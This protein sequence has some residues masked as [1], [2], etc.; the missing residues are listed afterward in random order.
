M[1]TSVI[2]LI[3]GILILAFLGIAIYFIVV[4]GKTP[5]NIMSM[6]PKTTDSIAAARACGLGCA[7]NPGS[8]CGSKCTS[9]SKCC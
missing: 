9:G 1:N 8:S 3:S 2:Y 6:T 5:K 4:K 7:Y